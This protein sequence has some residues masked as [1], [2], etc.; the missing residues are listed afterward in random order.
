MRLRFEE[1]LQ[2]LK[3]STKE[4]IEGRERLMKLKKGVAKAEIDRAN[5]ILEK[6]LGNTNNI[7]TVIDAVYAMGQTIAERKGV[8]RN[9]KRK[10][11]K[12]QEGP[13][14]RRIRKLEKQIKELRQILA[15]TSNEIH[16]RKIKRKSTKK[17]K[18]ILQKLKKWADQ[19]LN[20][21]EELICVK[22]KALD[23][24]RYCN[25]KMK[26]LKI[27]DARIRNNKMFQEDQEMF[28]R[29]TQGTKQLKGNVPRMEKCEEFWAGIWE[30][31]T[32]TPKR[33][34]MNTVAKKM[35]QKV[36]NMQEFT[37]TEK[38]LHQ[39]VKKRKNWSAPGID[40]VQNF[41][42]KKFRGAWSAIL[43][44]FNQWLELPD[45]IPD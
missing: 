39:T 14:N 33:K 22:E 35:G 8:K 30:N 37:I 25:I 45:E 7:C 12:N 10:E 40:G 5:K 34:W 42:W 31:N 16:R 29:K 4:N 6:H 21:N 32:K 15:W 27:K 23:K 43:R 13:P 11:N 38:K 9:E 36:A 2:T 18:E 44:C 19:Q 26:R 3:A 28:S 20:R 41:W 1:I 17:E 24:L